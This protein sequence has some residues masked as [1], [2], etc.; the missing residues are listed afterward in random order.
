MQSLTTITYGTLRERAIAI[1]PQNIWAYFSRGYAKL[2]LGDRQ[3]GIADM[4]IVVQFYKGYDG[5]SF[6][7]IARGLVQY[8]SD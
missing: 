3:G 6:T 8:G 1:D 4:N 7:A 2:D 5:D